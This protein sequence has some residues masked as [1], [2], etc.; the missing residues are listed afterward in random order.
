MEISA[1]AERSKIQLSS[2]IV[3]SVPDN[4]LYTVIFSFANCMYY[5]M[6]L[7]VSSNLFIF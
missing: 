5:K 7:Y 4:L 3:C 1:S 2:R 6:Y